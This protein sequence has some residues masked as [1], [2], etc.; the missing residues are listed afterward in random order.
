MIKWRLRA[1]FFSGLNTMKHRLLTALTLCVTLWATAS[2]SGAHLISDKAQRQSV[3]S[4]FLQRVEQLPNGDLFSVFDSKLSVQ[5]REALEFLYAYMSLSDITSH[6]GAYYLENV[7]C[8]LKARK[9]MAWGVPELEFR[10]FVLPLRV[11]NE[12]LDDCRKIFYEDLK[13][14]LEGL[15]MYDAVLEVNHWCHEK[16]TYKPSDGRT[17]S[18]LASILTAEGRCGEESTFTV[19]ALRA[20]GIPARQVYTPRWAHTD[21][22]HAWVEAW[23]DGNWYFFGACEPEAVLNL[24]WFNEPASRAMMVHTRVFGRYDG[25]EEVMYRTPRYTEINVIDNYASTAK[26]I[27]KVVDKAGNGVP[28]AKVEFKVYN[29]AEFYT[30]ATKKTEQDGETFLTSGQG[31]MLVWASKD[32]EYGYSKLSFGRDEQITIVLDSAARDIELDVIPPA[33]WSNIPAMTPEQKERNAERFAYEDSLR[34]A[35]MATFYT[36]ERAKEF[37]AQNGLEET[38]AKFMVAA[39]G[40]HAVIGEYLKSSDSPSKYALLEQVAQKDLRD[41]SLEVLN[42]H[43]FN[44]VNLGWSEEIFNKYVLNPRISTEMLTP[45]KSILQQAFSEE[46]IAAFR[47][48]PMSIAS[49]VADNIEIDKNCNLGSI[50]IYPE[51]VLRARISDVRSRDIFFVA[52]C[53]ALGGPA[54]IDSV[55]GK[56][57]IISKEEGFVDINFEAIEQG[58]APTGVFA[59]SYSP[60]K[61]IADPGYY[62]HFTISKIGS[63][64]SPRL[65]NY[66]EGELDMGG[67]TSW[68]TTFKGGTSLDEVDYVLV[69][70]NRMANGGVLAKLSFFSIAE[71]GKT[72][73]D[74]KIRQDENSIMVIGS[75]DSESLYK[76]LDI[77][78]LEIGGARSILSTT[79]RGYFVVAVLG[80][81]GEPTN[82]A[83]R[84]IAAAASELE[85]WGRPMLLIFPDEASARKFRL[86]DFPGLPSNIVYGI[87]IDGSIARGIASGAKLNGQNLPL[88]VIS[89]T[90]NRVVFASGGYTIGL[91]DQLSKTIKQL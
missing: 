72:V 22:N 41:G 28:E 55:T 56:V 54:R 6:D 13:P 70:G 38:A 60:S 33:G 48:A 35:Y 73:V 53:R 2:C 51:G 36:S 9:E 21:D 68:K 50:Q 3:H 12:N 84:D 46:E 44:S 49:W 74:L 23:V 71:G 58:S 75:L 85:Q 45:Y 78:T 90:F 79:G 19:A 10:H 66:E 83:L 8:T 87:D 86:S 37:A 67:G 30:V 16:V 11:N 40:N 52:L 5:Q 25:P 88:V 26:A 14:R 64:G 47:A 80:V 39:C 4:D 20:V 89:D 24:G 34:H 91:G 69:T 57:Q 7:D 77:N 1:P 65:L 61:I 18:P 63:D 32:G 82:H 43:L 15:S 29:Y 59:A 76:P 31:D 17:S 42:D 81:G 62:S 27:V